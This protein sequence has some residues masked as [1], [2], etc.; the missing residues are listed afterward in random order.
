MLILEDPDRMYITTLTYNNM[1]DAEGTIILPW[2]RCIQF[3]TESIHQ[4]H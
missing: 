4:S 1:L 3:V 2:H